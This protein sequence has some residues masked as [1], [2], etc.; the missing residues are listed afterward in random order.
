MKKLKHYRKKRVRHFKETQFKK[1]KP[2]MRVNF[3]K[4]VLP[5]VNG[6]DKLGRVLV[7]KFLLI[8]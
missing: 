7:G 3:Y 2:D 6:K 4:G 1:M 8:D 5:T